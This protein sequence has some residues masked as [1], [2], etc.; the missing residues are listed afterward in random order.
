MWVL[1]DHVQGDEGYTPADRRS[2]G[3]DAID[4]HGD[5]HWHRKLLSPISGQVVSNLITDYV[6]E[7]H[8]LRHGLI[9]VSVALHFVNDDIP[10]LRG[11]P[12]Q[13]PEV[14]V[15]GWEGLP[16][17][18]GDHVGR[19]GDVMQRRGQLLVGEEG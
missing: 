3:V 9:H 7:R 1:L 5:G 4:L 2:L 19:I 12:D 16:P 10:G 15:G 6:V 18:A 14:P 17:H 13:T 8:A 11:D